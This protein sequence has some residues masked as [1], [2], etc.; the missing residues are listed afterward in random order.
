MVTMTLQVI[1]NPTNPT[2]ALDIG[3]DTFIFPNNTAWRQ[4]AVAYTAQAPDAGKYLRLKFDF[5]PNPFPGAVAT[6]YANIGKASITTVKP[7]TWPRENLLVNGDFEDYSSLPIGTNENN[8]Y[9]DLFNYIGHYTSGD[10]PGWDASSNPSSAYYGLQCMLWVAPPQPAMG[11]VSAWF[12]EAIEQYV[13][14]EA[15]QEGQTYYVDFIAGVNASGWGPGG[16]YTWPVT[17]PNMVVDVYWVAPDHNDLS[18]MENTDW[19]HILS[20]EPSITGPLLGREDVPSAEWA[21]AQTS[22]TAD[23]SLDGK[24]FYVVA[25]CNDSSILY[26][27][28][29]EI[30]I[31]KEPRAAIGPYTCY[32][33]RTYY[34]MTSAA[35]INLDCKVDL[36]DLELFVDNWL[37]CN[38]PVGCN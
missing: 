37:D 28:F 7:D 30:Y 4:L 14:A 34:G 18:G 35:D 3:G 36:Y 6:G 5:G 10:I 27:T 20:L 38:D 15:I 12:T 21:S 22:F 19:G 29:E 26:P 11:R 16:G 32:E 9:L 1:D 17:D 31:S 33:Q 2:S 23:A 8:G 24:S 13:E 25:Y